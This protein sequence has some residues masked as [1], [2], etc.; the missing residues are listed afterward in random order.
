[1]GSEEHKSGERTE[2]QGARKDLGG[3]GKM[4]H[5][6]KPGWEIEV[7]QHKDTKPGREDVQEDLLEIDLDEEE[8]EISRKFLAIAVLYS[9]KSFNAK[10]LFVE[11]RNTWGISSMGHIEKLSD[12]SFKLEF[13]KEEE[14]MKAVEGGPWKHKGG[15]IVVVHYDGITRPSEVCIDSISLWVRLYDV[16]PVMMKEAVARQLS[17]ELGKF[18]IMDG[19]SPGYL[20]VRVLF[21]LKQALVP[22]LKIKIKGR[23]CMVIKVS[24]KTYHNFASY[25]GVLATRQQTVKRKDN[26]MK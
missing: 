14:K 13:H 5:E 22:Q 18:V 15:T 1:M 11:M 2:G 25:V 16:P 23:G 20:R 3:G 17:T 7:Y 9:R 12:Y 21:P 24:M 10:H 19:R 6:K 8:E 26:T 4:R